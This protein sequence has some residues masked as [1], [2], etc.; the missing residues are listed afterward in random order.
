M[1]DYDVIVVGAG[2]NGL[3]A[4][5]VLAKEG[6][7]VLDLEKNGYV[8]GMA[9]TREVIKGFKHNVGAWV[10]MFFSRKHMEL[11]GLEKY[12]L[13]LIEPTSSCCVLGVPGENPFI[14]Y[15]D[16]SKLIDHLQKDHG[17]D[18]ARGFVGLLQFL[19]PFAEIL[20][21]TRDTPISIG[22]M[23]DQAPNIQAK[24]AL[25]KIIYGS[26]MDV[27]D[28]FFPDPQ[29]HRHIRSAIGGMGSDGS[30]LGPYDLGTACAFAYHMVPIGFGRSWKLVKGGMGMLSEALKRSFEEKGGDVRLNARVKRILVKNDNAIGVE[31]ADGEK[32]ASKVVLSNIDAYSTFMGMVGE[33]NLPSDFV[34]MVKGIKYGTPYIQIHFALKELP[35]FT[36]D[37]A[38]INKD[39][40]RWFV[41]RTYGP[42]EFQRCL[43]AVRWGRLPEKP[44]WTYYIPSIWDDSMA[45]PGYHSLTLY[46]FD[47]PVMAPGALHEKLK[48]EMVDKLIDDVDRHAPNFRDAIL[49]RV[50][51]TS[52]HFERMFGITKG[53]YCHGRLLPQQMFDF[54]PV[55]GWSGYNTPV[56]NLYLC[57]SACH[58][59][60][61]V[62]GMPGYNS[63]REV[64]KNWKR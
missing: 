11:L 35:E 13:E 64:L 62:T 39:N 46:S 8:G 50:V 51:F 56:E 32:I 31:L 29:K 24:D 17:E 3:T 59:G 43:D 57:G 28:E 16:M 7:K 34:H 52:M 22:A 49:D 33:E 21:A 15:S 38:F 2:H 12:G 47:F 23:I 20:A 54:R 4:A 37:L 26:A 1:S 53:D 30:S 36:R 41:N 58:P 5:T 42:E 10:L 18:A 60:A 6:L 19:R 44:M 14:M 25:R 48:V 63:A 40:L 55:V 27:V 61:G 45:P 9:A